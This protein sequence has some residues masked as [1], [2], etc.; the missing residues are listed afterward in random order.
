MKEYTDI[1]TLI[2][3]TVT[4]IGVVGGIIAGGVMIYKY[5]KDEY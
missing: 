5:I 3:M 4:T 2:L 1:L